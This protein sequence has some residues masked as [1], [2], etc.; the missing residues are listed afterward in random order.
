MGELAPGR[1]CL[2]T[3]YCGQCPHYRPITRTA[4]EVR[5]LADQLSTR[6]YNPNIRYHRRG[7]SGH[8]R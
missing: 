7:D 5:Q 3:C 1:Y 2:A 8:A 6:R 4:R